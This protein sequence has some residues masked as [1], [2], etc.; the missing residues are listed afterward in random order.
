MQAGGGEE[1]LKHSEPHL[2]LQYQTPLLFSLDLN[3][4]RK[5]KVWTKG[6]HQIWCMN[7]PPIRTELL[8]HF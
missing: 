8:S 6:E 7:Q 3:L 4:N 1:V 5:P 2:N